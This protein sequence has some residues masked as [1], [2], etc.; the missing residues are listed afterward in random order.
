[1]RK[2][3]TNSEEIKIKMFEKNKIK[4][5]DKVKELVFEAVVQRCSVKQVF[6]EVSQ[7]S[8]ENAC[9]RVSWHRC[10]P[11]NLA[12]SLRTPFFIEHLWWLLLWYPFKAKFLSKRSVL[13]LCK[14]G[15]MTWGQGLVGAGTGTLD[16][17]PP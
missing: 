4:L 9:A 7:N 15:T 11:V 13:A 12:N 10:F 6:L 5:F 17:G 14:S 3:R 1:M 2:I 16:P 8:Q